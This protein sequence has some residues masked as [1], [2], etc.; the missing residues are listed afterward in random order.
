MNFSNQ[1]TNQKTTMIAEIDTTM[2]GAAMPAQIERVNLGLLHASPTNPRKHFD[3]E[4]LAEL[5]SSIEEHGVQM[6]LLARP[7]KLEAGKYEIVA[8]ERRYRA[9]TMLVTMLPERMELAGE[10]EARVARLLEL[11]AA[12][13]EVPVIVK[14]LD[15]ATVLEL[16][17]IENLQRQDLTALEEARGYERMLDLPERGYT[18]A[19]I[20]LKIGKSVNTVL[21]KLKMLRAPVALQEA[22]E[23]GKVGERH[24]VL[25]A[26]V[27][28]EKAREEIAKR[29][30]HG[31]YDYDSDSREPLSVRATLMII[32]RDYCASLKGVPWKLEDAD[33]V[34]EAGA[35]ATCPH[36]ARFA[37]EQDS[38]LAAELGNGRGQTDP[39]TCLNPGCAKRKHDAVF[40][41]KKQEAKGGAVTVLK[42]EEAAKI[43]SDH[44]SL[45][46]T[47]VVKL[48][49]RPGYDQTGHW[50]NDKLPTWRELVEDRLPAGALHVANVKAVGVVELVDV[51]M[52]VE[53]AR[54][55]KKHGKEFAKTVA[56]GKR[57]MTEAEKRAKEKEAFDQKVSTRAKLCLMEYLR[58]RAAEKGMDREAALAVLETVL[59]EA[60]K[61]GCQLM[62]EVL[63]IAP[64]EKKANEYGVN[65]EAYREPILEAL[66][67]QDAGKPELDRLIM[68]G[69]ISKYV[70]AWGISFGSLKPLQGHFDFDEK[71]ITTLA[72]AEVRAEMEAKAAKKTPDKAGKAAKNST[73]PT[74]FSVDAEVSKTKA[75]DKRARGKSAKVEDYAE[76]ALKNA[77]AK[78]VK[79][80]RGLVED[81]KSTAAA[82][83]FDAQVT[84]AKAGV[85]WTTILGPMPAEGTK[86][87]KAWDALR[88][89]IYK[90]AKKAKGAK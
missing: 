19:R 62:A 84:Q 9:S 1:T 77:P 10:D 27:P 41:L 34:P 44:G 43:I 16:Q 63:G 66:R 42:P 69:V 51:R 49:E 8:G 6:P 40:K 11:Q 76:A 88:V 31:D 57:V 79:D 21:Y 38:D 80:M 74:D 32:N 29:I 46:T 3:A 26:R 72:T 35:C 56:S 83:E 36:F 13:M 85:A 90:A 5:A 47:A 15:D 24:L 4:A 75:A 18:P 54:G 39:L 53:A 86:P 20:A 67:A 81:W 64:R 17:L 68:L 23:A 12:R 2:T 89:K 61:D 59:M 45:R 50:G 7:S 60:G 58:D 55:H 52:A 78:V 71:T 70:K 28:G 82:G 33:M 37:A 87:R 48:D 30:L 22:L 25:V 14:D 73:D 65:A